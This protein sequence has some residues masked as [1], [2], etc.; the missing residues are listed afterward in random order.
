MWRKILVLLVAVSAGY[1]SNVSSQTACL[2]NAT[3]WYSHVMMSSQPF[4]CGTGTEAGSR[5]SSF[6][7]CR[8]ALYRVA[9]RT[10]IIKPIHESSLPPA[11][12]FPFSFLNIFIPQVM[13]QDGSSLPLTIWDCLALPYR[14][15]IRL[16]LPPE[17]RMGL[18]IQFPFTRTSRKQRLSEISVKKR[19]SRWAER[20]GVLLDFKN[21]EF[22]WFEWSESYH[23]V[24]DTGSLVSGRNGIRPASDKIGLPGFLALKGP[25]SEK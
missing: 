12:G 7:Y 8:C 15:A 14:S 3:F 17:F 20:F 1:V 2:E 11:S 25:L 19:G 16:R 13:L 24:D 6:G 23:D 21:N 4:F 22:S 5:S 9:F 18:D 10:P